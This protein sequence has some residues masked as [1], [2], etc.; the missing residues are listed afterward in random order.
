M[1]CWMSYW[2]PRPSVNNSQ[3]DMGTKPVRML[4]KW[5]VKDDQLAGSPV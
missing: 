4:A 3:A 1:K 2:M 5:R